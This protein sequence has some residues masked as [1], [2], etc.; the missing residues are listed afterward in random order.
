MT[1]EVF[2]AEGDILKV[3]L[4]VHINTEEVGPAVL[5]EL[6]HVY[7]QHI[8]IAFDFLVSTCEVQSVDIHTS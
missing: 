5:S 6:R 8:A 3:Y 4:T 7:P 2:T 1:N